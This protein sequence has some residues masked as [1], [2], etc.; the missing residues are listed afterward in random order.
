[1]SDIVLASAAA[2]TVA[3]DAGETS[4]A[5]AEVVA[6]LPEPELEPELHRRA[7]ASRCKRAEIQS[8]ETVLEYEVLPRY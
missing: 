5:V 3:A 8:K 2:G 4:V 1:M 7:F 6:A